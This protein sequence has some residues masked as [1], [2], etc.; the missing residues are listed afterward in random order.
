MQTHSAARVLSWSLAAAGVS[1]AYGQPL[2]ELP[3]TDVADPRVA[4]LLSGAHR[5]V[6]G[7]VA[8][9]HIGHGELVIVGP[10]SVPEFRGAKESGDWRDQLPSGRMVIDDPVALFELGPVIRAAGESDGMCLDLRIDLASQVV[11]QAMAAQVTGAWEEPDSDLVEELAGTSRVVVVAGPGVVDQQCVGDLRALAAAGRFGVLNTWGAKGVFHWQS[12]HHLATAGLQEWDFDLGGLPEA[13]L[14]LGVGLDYR[15]APAHLW[16]QF[17]HRIIAPAALGPLAEH[18]DGSGAFPDVPQLRNRLAAVTQAGWAPGITPLKPSL[19][20]RHYAEVLGRGGVVAADSGVAGF[21]VARTFST[22]QLGTVF[23]PSGATSGW[24]S[25]CVLVARLSDP[26]RPG[27]AVIDGPI[28]EMTQAVLDGAARLGVRIGIEVWQADGQI[29]DAEAHVARL[30]GLI[31]HF[32]G[33]ATLATDDRQLD[34]M[35]D[36]AGPV[37]AWLNDKNESAGG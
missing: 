17:P 16:E 23:V 11:P 6:N 5:A 33:Q 30:V 32:G 20:T 15:E 3:V 26:L 9:A 19:V 14:V 2:G 10:R 34:E 36:A 7:T 35:T 13:D 25:A 28:D 31:A 8:I 4:I 27:L 12:R 1:V 22:T 24:A 29:L 21:W 18:M 37:R